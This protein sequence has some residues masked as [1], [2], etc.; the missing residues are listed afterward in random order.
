MSYSTFTLPKV[1][2]TFALTVTTQ[3]I[4]RQVAPVPLSPTVQQYLLQFRSLALSMTTEKAKSELLVAPL[5]V[6]AWQQSR[7]KV[8]IYSGVELNVDAEAGLNGVCDYLF[9][10]G[11]QLAYV[12]A[13]LLAVVEAKRDSIPE[14]LGQ[15]AAEAV[16]IWRF[17]R[18]RNHPVEPVFGC[19]TTGS[20]WKFLRLDG[21]N[22]VVDFDEYSIFQPDQILGILLQIIGHT[23]NP[24]EPT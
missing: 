8:S 3:P 13:P 24:E 11:E 16:A 12:T 9:G 15:C 10:R 14:G 21:K 2:S 17:N 19:V 5:L 7:T 20:Q 23:P 4:F 18:D 1:E 22:L 6:E